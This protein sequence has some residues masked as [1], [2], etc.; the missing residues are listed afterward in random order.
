MTET[1]FYILM[2]LREDMHGYGIVQRVE[3]LKKEKF[4][5]VLEPCTAVSPKWKKIV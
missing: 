4:V 1:R 3:K 5:S 2:C